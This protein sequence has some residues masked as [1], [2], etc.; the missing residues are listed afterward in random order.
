MKGNLINSKRILMFIVFLFTCILIISLKN[1][2]I[3]KDHLNPSSKRDITVNLIHER[4]KLI[5]DYN[6]IG[7]KETSTLEEYIILRYDLN[8]M[9]LENHSSISSIKNLN[10]ILP[11]LRGD[12]LDYSQDKGKLI[13]PLD[14]TKKSDS[15]TFSIIEN[16][17]RSQD[18]EVYYVHIVNL[19]MDSI[20][21]WIKK[22]TFDTEIIY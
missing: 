17:S 3:T 14:I 9:K 8:S 20:T 11:N 22:D 5:I 7:Y 4:G 12:T 6:W 21:G 19:P 1:N 10:K 18:I 2:W 16:E 13:V 15:I